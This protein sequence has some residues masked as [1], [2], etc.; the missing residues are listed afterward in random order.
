MIL[1]MAKEVLRATGMRTMADII[2][3]AIFWAIPFGWSLSSVEKF[4]VWSFVESYQSTP[5]NEGEKCKKFIV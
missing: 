5:T 3:E 2:K 4:V 1:R